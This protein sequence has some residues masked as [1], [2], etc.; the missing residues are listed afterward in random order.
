[1]P[2]DIV[3]GIHTG[4]IQDFMPDVASASEMRYS[5]LAIIVEEWDGIIESKRRLHSRRIIAWS[6]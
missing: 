2:T 6:L 5:E 1:V 3:G 4:F